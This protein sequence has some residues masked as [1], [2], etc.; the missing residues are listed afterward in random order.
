MWDQISSRLL[1]AAVPRLDPE[2]RVRHRLIPLD[3]PAGHNTNSLDPSRLSLPQ[4]STVLPRTFPSSKTVAQ[5]P[6]MSAA[7]A[8]VV[9]TE[10]LVRHHQ[11]HQAAKPLPLGAYLTRA[12]TT[13]CSRT[14]DPKDARWVRLVKY[15]SPHPAHCSPHRPPAPRALPTSD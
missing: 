7:D 13:D 12:L 3:S 5:S 15:R 8:K 2:T 6:K 4:P 9:K 10:P 14:Q 11:K 1:A